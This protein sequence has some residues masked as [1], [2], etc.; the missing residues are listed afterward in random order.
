MQRTEDRM[1]KKAESLVP[2]LDDYVFQENGEWRIDERLVKITDVIGSRMAQSIKMSFLQGMG[3]NAKIDKGLKTAMT[4]DLIEN[5]A[6]WLNT[7][8]GF[9][10]FE[11]KNTAAYIT[12]H[13]EQINFLLGLIGQ[14]TGQNRGFNGQRGGSA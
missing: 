7:I 12:K 5:K 13:P 9:L 10:G 11:P 8:A 2:S 6:P 3:A 1:F 14:A 4:Q